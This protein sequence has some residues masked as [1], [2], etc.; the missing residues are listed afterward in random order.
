MSMFGSDENGGSQVPTQLQ[1]IVEGPGSV[2]VSE[3]KPVPD[4]DYLQVCYSVHCSCGCLCHYSQ[5]YSLD[6][7]TMP[8]QNI[9]VFQV[10]HLI[11][12]ELFIH[13]LS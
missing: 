12:Y 3:Y 1:S 2:M 9:V 5:M 10:V 8:I 6:A 7:H 11:S 4:V 13:L